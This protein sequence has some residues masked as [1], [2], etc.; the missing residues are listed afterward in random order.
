MEMFTQ[1][2]NPVAD[3]TNKARKPLGARSIGARKDGHVR[4][5][6]ATVETCLTLDLVLGVE[7][8]ASDGGFAVILDGFFAHILPTISC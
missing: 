5:C 4:G 1:A 6:T 2:N 7:W 3:K 8:K